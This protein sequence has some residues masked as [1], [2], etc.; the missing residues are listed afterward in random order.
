MIKMNSICF[1]R[2]V[3]KCFFI[4]LYI[5]KCFLYILGL[6]E[7]CGIIKVRKG[8]E[9]FLLNVGVLFDL[10]YWYIYVWYKE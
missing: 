1:I 8:V 9:M 3:L 4:I 7:F 2:Y 10:K 5:V 6:I